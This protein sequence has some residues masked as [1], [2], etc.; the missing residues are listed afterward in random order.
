MWL[1]HTE[2]GV[3]EEFVE[4]NTPPYAILSHTWMNEEITFVEMTVAV[5]GVQM[6]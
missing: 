3:L 6:A 4:S 1:L 2:T 5:T